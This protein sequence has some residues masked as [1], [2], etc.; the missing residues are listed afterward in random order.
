MLN[1]KVNAT[2]AQRLGD[3]QIFTFSNSHIIK[4]SNKEQGIMNLEVKADCK[5]NWLIFKFSNFHIPTS[6]HGKDLVKKHSP[7]DRK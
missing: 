2:E 3:F 4:I 5:M 1:E 6:Q 7:H